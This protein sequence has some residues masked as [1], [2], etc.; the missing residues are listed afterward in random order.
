MQ[1]VHDLHLPYDKDKLVLF[2]GPPCQG[3]STSNQRTRGAANEKN[4]LY[5]SFVELVRRVTPGWVVFENVRNLDS[6]AKA[7]GSA[8]EYSNR[9]WMTQ[10]R[11]KVDFL[12]SL[13]A[14]HW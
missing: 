8:F 6:D 12:F 5:R 9:L 4:W 3:F 13:L 2:G 7:M 1:S 11:H 14:C 10:M